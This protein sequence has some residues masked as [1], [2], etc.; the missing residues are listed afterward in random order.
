MD[1]SAVTTTS[2]TL[3]VF[4]F[5]LG[6][7]LIVSPY[8]LGYVTAQAR[9]EQTIAGIIVAVLAAVRYFAPQLR[10]TSWV[11]LIV[12]AW[13]IIA[14]FATGYQ[15]SAAYWNEVIFGVLIGLAALWNANL[16]VS[17]LYHG[18]TQ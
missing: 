16:G 11:N 1:D 8:I 10:W 4:N 13:M 2:R 5:I 12:G 7:W 17:T 18:H 14:P 6:V 3:S 15:V 9:W